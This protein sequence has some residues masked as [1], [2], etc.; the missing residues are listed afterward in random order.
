M[1]NTKTVNIKPTFYAF[2]SAE[3]DQNLVNLSL[4]IA[5]CKTLHA[6]LDEKYS[7]IEAGLLVDVDHRYRDLLD[8][9]WTHVQPNDLERLEN[10]A[11][12]QTKMS[13]FYDDLND[14]NHTIATEGLL[15]VE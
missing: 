2:T 5:Q 12:L 15:H 9:F 11:H 6:L 8:I 7:R 3:F 4:S 13:D 14:I 10:E 1:L